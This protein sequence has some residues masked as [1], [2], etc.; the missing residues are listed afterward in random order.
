VTTQAATQLDPVF[1]G[2]VIERSD[3]LYNEA[4]TLYNAMIDKHPSVIARPVDAADVISAVGVA[5]ELDLEVAVRGGGHNGP[6]LGSVDDG[7]VIDLTA[8]RGVR[9]DPMARTAQVAGGA[10]LGDVDH[11][12][13]AFGLAAPFGILSTTGVGGLTLGGGVGNLTRT[14]GLSIDQLL[15]ADVVL[16]DGS[17][18]TADETHEPDLF[19]ALRGGGGNFGVVTSFTFRLHPVDTVIAGPMLWSVER[20]EEVLAFY[21]DFLRAA[22]EE[23]NGWFAFLTVPPAPPFPEELHLRNVCGVLWCYV[24]TEEDARDVLSPVRALGPLLDG[25][26]PVPFPAIQ[27]AF[28]GLYPPGLQWYW[29]VHVLAAIDEDAVKTN[30]EFGQRLPSVHSTTHMYPIDGAAGRVGEDETAWAHRDARWVQVIAAVDPDPRNVANLRTWASEYWSA[31]LPHSTGGG[32]VNMMMLEGDERIRATYGRHWERL[33]RIKA[34]YDPH[35]LFHVN[36]NIKP[37]ANN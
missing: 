19:W 5:R 36:Q 6:G 3:P 28:D 34:A 2:D 31:L 37:G 7:L 16:A 35:N 12:T 32:Y 26:A 10:L 33:S 21:R 27:S 18:V 23:L 30:A 4:R 22:P 25:V 17:Y 24:G 1:R 15:S 11:A 13:H 8:M 14:L 20:A 9:V 29:K